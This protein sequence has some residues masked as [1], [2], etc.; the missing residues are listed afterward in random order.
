[1]A[2][3]TYYGNGSSGN[4]TNIDY[5]MK[6][7]YLPVMYGIIFVVGVLGNVTSLLVYLVK[8]RPWKSSSIILVNLATTDLLYMLS[9]PFLIYYYAQS[10]SWTLGD[11]MCRFVRFGFHFNL[12]GS[13]LFLTCLAVFRYVAVV[14]PLQAAK[15]QKRR[16]GL[17]ACVLTWTLAA[18][19]YFELNKTRLQRERVWTIVIMQYAFVISMDLLEKKRHQKITYVFPK[20]VNALMVL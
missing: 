17:L 14:H 1:M 9:M 11:F 4:C 12:Y 7:Y 18:P 2:S 20:C 19:L 15:I 6:R 16:W 10:D 13:I 8:V 3:N 5:L